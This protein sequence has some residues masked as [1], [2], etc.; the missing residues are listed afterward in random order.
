MS[1]E[2]T[3]AQLAAA[4]RQAHAALAPFPETCRPTTLDQ[5]YAVQEVLHGILGEQRTQGRSGYKIGCTTA[6]MQE[7]LGIDHPCAGSVSGADVY[8]GQAELELSHFINA[9]VECEIGVVVAND[10]DPAGAPFDRDSV[11]E[12]VLAV[13]PAIEIVDNRYI[14]GTEIGVPSLIADDFFGA[15]A[16]LGA[17]VDAWRDI[18]LAAVRGRVFVDGEERDSGLGEAVMGNPLEAVAWFANMK[19]AQG[20]ILKAGEFILTGSLTVV[21]WID[22]PCRVRIEIDQL[23]TAEVVFR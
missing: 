4:A 23:G 20:G 12:L 15:G 11:A 14:G 7:N 13:M 16:V 5:G 2:M 19:A 17:R 6:V 3:A 9:G 21:Q 10:L 22:A 18:D 1:R 8:Q